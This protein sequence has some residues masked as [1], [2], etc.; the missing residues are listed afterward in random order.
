[1]KVGGGK[2]RRGGEKMKREER[3]RSTE[4]ET[5]QEDTESVIQKEKR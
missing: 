5:R 2:E 1:M 4:I 3:K